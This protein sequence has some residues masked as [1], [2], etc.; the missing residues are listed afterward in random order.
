M[1]GDAAGQLRRED[2]WRRLA[3]LAVGRADDPVKLA[4]RPEGADPEKLD[5]SAL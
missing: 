1:R 5:L 3:Q 4:L 2:A